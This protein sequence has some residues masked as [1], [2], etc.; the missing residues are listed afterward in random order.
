MDLDTAPFPPIVSLANDLEE[1]KL[2]YLIDQND[3]NQKETYGTL[4]KH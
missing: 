2:A 4:Y 1:Y 3:E